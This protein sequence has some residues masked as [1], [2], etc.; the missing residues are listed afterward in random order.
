MPMSFSFVPKPETHRN[1]VRADCSGKCFVFKLPET[2]ILEYSFTSSTV[3]CFQRSTFRI[4]GSFS[5]SPLQPP[6]T[7]VL[8]CHPFLNCT[9]RPPKR[10][11]SCQACGPRAGR[12]SLFCLDHTVLAGEVPKP[13]RQKCGLRPTILHGLLPSTGCG[14]R[15]TPGEEGGQINPAC[16][17]G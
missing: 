10:F 12:R 1:I 15:E 8:A 13:C 17:Y 6:P 3:C 4:L 14:G 9:P 2:L 16:G 11:A 5:S 7:L